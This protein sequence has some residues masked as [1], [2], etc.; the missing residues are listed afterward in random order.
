MAPAR[1]RERERSM[2]GV[3]V[4]GGLLSVF[5][6]EVV[7]VCDVCVFFETALPCRVANLVLS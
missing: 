2:P 4:M 1:D 3:C 6:E 5:V 7:G